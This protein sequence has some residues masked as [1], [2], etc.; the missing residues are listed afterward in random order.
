MRSMTYVSA[1]AIIALIAFAF[2]ASRWISQPPPGPTGPQVQTPVSKT[3]TASALDAR[4][5]VARVFGNAVFLSDVSAPSFAST[6]L[7]G[8]GSEDLAVVVTAN[9]DQSAADS[10]L[11]NWSVMDVRNVELPD[12]NAA[13]YTFHQ[14]HKP[15]KLRKNQQ[16]VGVIHGVGGMGW[17]SPDARQAFLLVNTPAAKLSLA[18]I[19]DLNRHGVSLPR[20][21]MYPVEALIATSA[22][23][24]L[25][26]YWAGAQYAG[27]PLKS[28]TELAAARE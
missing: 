4:I 23:D 22:A 18:P 21:T 25:A 5:A 11:R 9:P 12:P 8:D 20:T 10:E 27:V 7:N 15:I 26:V 14:K 1:I 3:H 16:V 24:T 19:A 28:T 17:R 13:V 2:G 6:D